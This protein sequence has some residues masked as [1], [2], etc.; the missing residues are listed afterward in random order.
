MVELT[1]TNLGIIA[2]VSIAAFTVFKLLFPSVSPP[3]QVEDDRETPFTLAEIAK[4]DGKEGRRNYIGLNGF[5][6]DVTS[7]PN[8]QEGGTYASFAGRDISIAC[9][10]YSTDDKYLG[11]TY[12]PDGNNGLNFDQQQNL[13]QFYIMFCQKYPIKGYVKLDKKEQ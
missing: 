10:H 2:G 4:F 3:P 1:P 9:A 7:S 5:V 13:I 8:F 6:F 12:D 11:E